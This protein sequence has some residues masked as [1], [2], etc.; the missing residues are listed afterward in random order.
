MT[1]IV[2]PLNCAILETE[3]AQ[4][5]QAHDKPSH[6]QTLQNSSSAAEQR[7][8]WLIPTDGDLSSGCSVPQGSLPASTRKWVGCTNIASSSLELPDSAKLWGC[9]CKGDK[10]QLT[11]SF[12]KLCKMDKYFEG[13]P[14]ISRFPEVFS[15]YSARNLL[16]KALSTSDSCNNRHCRTVAIHLL[17]RTKTS[18]WNTGQAS[19]TVLN[20]NRLNSSIRI[21]TSYL[22]VRNNE[23]H[24]SSI[25]P[26]DS[27]K[28]GR[29]IK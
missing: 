7:S 27:S 25:N 10:S 2:F 22:S 19:W 21:F 5:S 28:M 12:Y 20:F 18:F 6:P 1:S 11:V 17:S 16:L 26:K 15:P 3:K 29:L 8:L 4:I 9:N 13:T 24:W 23:I 14:N